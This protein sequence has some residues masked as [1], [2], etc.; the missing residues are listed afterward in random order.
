L[1]IIGRELL[2]LIE[3]EREIR[4]NLSSIGHGDTFTN[5]MFEI[6]LCLFWRERRRERGRGRGRE[7][8]G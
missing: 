1:I 7:R 5:K 8:I 2:F 3:R 6:V 4:P